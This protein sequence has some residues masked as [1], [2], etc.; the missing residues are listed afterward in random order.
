MGDPFDMPDDDYTLSWRE[1]AEQEYKVFRTY[2]R[3]S[4]CAF[5]IDASRAKQNKMKCKNKIARVTGR[6][7][8]LP[9]D[10]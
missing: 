6:E 9:L 10:K 2:V 1:R 4:F 8:K 3:M 5:F 7:T